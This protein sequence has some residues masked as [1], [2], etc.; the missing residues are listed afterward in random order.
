MYLGTLHEWSLIVYG[1][2]TPPQPPVDWAKISRTPGPNAMRTEQAGNQ[3]TASGNNYQQVEKP[4][5]AFEKGWEMNYGG[6]SGGG[7]V[8][9]FRPFKACF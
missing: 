6:G 9:G 2:E 5:E 4:R 3:P 1:T 8:C 7:T